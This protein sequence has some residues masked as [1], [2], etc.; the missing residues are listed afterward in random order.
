MCNLYSLSKH[1]QAILEMVTAMSKDIGNF[2]PMPG[3]F[4]DYAA[5]IITAGSEGLILRRARWG[6]PSPRFVQ[7]EATK[8]RAARLDK[9]GEAYDFAELLRHEPDSGVTNVRKTESR[10]WGPFQG[11][12]RRCLVP[13]T[14][15]NE[16]DQVERGPSAWFALGEDRPLAFFAGVWTEDHECVR[17]KS[18]GME[19]CDLFGFLTTDANAEVRRFHPKAM[20][21][22]LTS[23]EERDVW[24][25]APWDEAKALQR[26][27]PDG[28]LM[29]VQRGGKRDPEGDDG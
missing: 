9:A 28:S 14:A 29:V 5:P 13:F 4:P 1:V 6:M 15:F 24:M 17:K 11:V 21:V 22:I 12:D 3:V 8:R 20:P 27:L 10:H 16:P 18:T 25:R 7:L 23:T 19:T 2:A 26:P